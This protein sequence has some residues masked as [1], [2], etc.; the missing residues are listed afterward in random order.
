MILLAKYKK[1]YSYFAF[2]PSS[3]GI[4]DFILVFFCA[5]CATDHISSTATQRGVG[6]TYVQECW[7]KATHHDLSHISEDHSHQHTE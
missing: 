7:P 6:F 2:I 5:Y 1:F 4:S 3:P